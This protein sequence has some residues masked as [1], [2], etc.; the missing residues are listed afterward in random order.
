[1]QDENAKNPDRLRP[2]KADLERAR[3]RAKRKEGAN[4]MDRPADPADHMDEDEAQGRT[5]RD[6]DKRRPE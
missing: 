1:M 3:E 6:L 5:I 2:T 4:P